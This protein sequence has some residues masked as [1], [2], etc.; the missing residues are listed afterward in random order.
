MSHWEG[1]RREGTRV[2]TAPAGTVLELEVRGSKPP[3]AAL[4]LKLETLAAWCPQRQCQA[5]KHSPDSFIHRFLGPTLGWALG[6]SRSSSRM[7]ALLSIHSHLLESPQKPFQ[8]ETILITPRRKKK[9][10]SW[11]CS[12]VLP[13]HCREI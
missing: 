5:W 4:G 7:P 10:G 13:L 2:C 12:D 8:V 6:Q 3:S 11:R 1:V 9:G